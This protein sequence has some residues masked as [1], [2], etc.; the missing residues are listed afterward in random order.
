MRVRTYHLKR[1]TEGA[2]RVGMCYADRRAKGSQE[3]SGQLPVLPY[4]PFRGRVNEAIHGDI[5]QVHVWISQ[6]P[7]H[8][9]VQC[10]TS[11]HFL[12][13]HIYIAPHH[14]NY[15]THSLGSLSTF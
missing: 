6:F 1:M 13:P 9:R 4:L 3:R 11:H 14:L 2:T 15:D 5:V 8:S 12:T 7:C 10:D